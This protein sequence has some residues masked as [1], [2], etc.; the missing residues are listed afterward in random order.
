MERFAYKSRD[1]AVQ[2]VIID[3][4]VTQRG[5][6]GFPHCHQRSLVWSYIFP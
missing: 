6:K 1:F 3:V 4:E 2:T 5:A